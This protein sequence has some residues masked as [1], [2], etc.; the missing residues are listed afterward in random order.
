MRER[1]LLLPC[2]F[3][4]LFAFLTSFVGG[5][6]IEK[7]GMP[8]I[9]K[10]ILSEGAFPLSPP[11]TEEDR[12]RTQLELQARE[13]AKE[14][15][16]QDDDYGDE[17]LVKLNPDGT[18]RQCSEG[19]QE[20]CWISGRWRLKSS[21][22]LL[23][24]LD[25]Q[26]YGPRRDTL[27]E[28]KIL[29]REETNSTSAA[30]CNLRCVGDVFVGK[31]CYAKQ[32]PAFFEEPIAASMKNRTG[33]FSLEQAVATDSVLPSPATLPQN[34]TESRDAKTYKPSD[35]YG[36]KFIMTVE[37]LNQRFSSAKDAEIRRNQPF[38]I[39]ALPIHFYANNTFQAF[40]ATKIL[41]G[42]FGIL[43]PEEGSDYCELWFQ[44]SLFGAGRSAPGSVYSEGIG[45]GHEDKRS[46][47]GEIVSSDKSDGGGQARLFVSGTVTYGSDLGTDARPEPVSKFQL[48]ETSDEEALTLV[49]DESQ[50]GV[51]E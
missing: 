20:G 33:S 3:A 19:Y 9:W 32:H 47:V 7:K 44:V 8:G 6:A 23:L 14:P 38:D 22:T 13:N 27:L 50:D 28:G 12:F 2:C 35:F 46:Y 40:G 21:D 42:R 25:R 24:A 29:R 31:F 41:R 4:F 43:S 26:Y 39:R 5:F 48:T 1:R 18:F 49:D 34:G 17:I 11:Q 45:L 10:L 30:A 36:R 37:P 16:Q 51:F 15:Q